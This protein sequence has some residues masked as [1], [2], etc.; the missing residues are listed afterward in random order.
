MGI[1]LTILQTTFPRRLEDNPTYHNWP[2]ENLKV[3]YGEGLY[4]GYR[5]YERLN[6]APL[7]P[8]GHGLSYTTFSYGKPS[9][10]KPVLA[11]SSKLT[12]TLAV[13]NT[14]SVAGAEIVQAYIHDKKSSLPRPEKELQAFTKVFLEAGE[15]KHI[16]LV[17]DK[18]SVGFYDTNQ[19]AWIAEEG[20][21]DVLI[22][23]SSQDI[24]YVGSPAVPYINY[25]ENLTLP[26]GRPFRS[27]SRNH[28]RG[29]FNGV[30]VVDET[31]LCGDTAS[32]VLLHCCTVSLY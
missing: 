5:H 32:T 24:R 7:F 31:G 18:Y 19:A 12:V 26:I 13:T 16:T 28:S 17:L 21:F 2:G 27:R 6:I 20:V 4:I 9:I 14:G 23:A 1:S 15:T 30:W 29:Y 22:G 8:F 3:V 25:S 10:S 11:D